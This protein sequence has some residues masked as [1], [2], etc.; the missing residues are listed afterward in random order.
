[1]TETRQRKKKRGYGEGAVQ[2][3]ADGRWMAQLMVGYKPD[4][5]RDIRSV[6]GKTRGECQKKLTELRRRRDEGLLGDPGAGKETVEAFLRRWLASIEGTMEPGSLRRHRDNVNRHIVPVVGRHRLSALKPEHVDGMLA[7]IRT[8]ETLKLAAEAMAKKQGRG[9]RTMPDVPSPRTVKYCFTTI[10]K[11]LDKAV[12][13]GAVPRNVARAVDRPQVPRIEIVALPPKYVAALLELLA[14]DGH[15]LAPLFTVAVFSGC[16]LGELL[17]LKW[18]DVGLD[19]GRTSVQRTLVG[20]KG[21]KPEFHEGGKTLRSRRNF[22]LSADALVA[23]QA[24]KDRQGFERQA[25]GDAY[26]DHGLI[27]ATPFGTPLDPANARKRLRAVL[28]EANL[29]EYTFHALRHAAATM[30]LVAGVN[31]KVAADRLGHHSVAFTLD[32]YTH[33]VESLDVDAAERLQA[34]MK[35][36]RQKAI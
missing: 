32:R 35:L 10:R 26:A 1:M 29:P 16:R 12:A 25:L 11:A 7:A 13:W 22:L 14:A 23:L 15:R 3:R 19:T 6:Y 8:G 24:Q 30:I 36:A 28:K 9:K 31:P 17:A 34:M 18:S 20:L 33:A 4:G 21:G 27:F 2:Q 5:S